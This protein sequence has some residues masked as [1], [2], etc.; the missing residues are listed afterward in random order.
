MHD[1]HL[2]GHHIHDKE[3]EQAL[4]KFTTA[5]YGKDGMLNR[6]Q[7]IAQMD[8]FYNVIR[9]RLPY[10]YNG[11]PAITPARQAAIDAA[12]A[13]L[14]VS[15]SGFIESVDI[16]SRYNF[17]MHPEVVSG[18]ITGD[19]AILKFLVNFKDENND[20]TI[21]KKQWDSYYGSVSAKVPNDDHFVDLITL[22]WSK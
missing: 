1:E 8:P 16:K 17:Q 5:I 12:F 2:G 3:A 7:W 19:E 10:P 20:G 14:D 13:K 22:A 21:S 6:D 18:E 9:P 15:G 4:F 11:L